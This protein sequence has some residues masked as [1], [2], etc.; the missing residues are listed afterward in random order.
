MNQRKRI[1]LNGGVE[2]LNLGMVNEGVKARYAAGLD[3][4]KG[5]RQETGILS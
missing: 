2:A 1:A 5:S 3:G 4:P